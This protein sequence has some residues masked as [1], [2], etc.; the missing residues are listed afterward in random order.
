MKKIKRMIRYAFSSPILQIKS[1]QSRSDGVNTSLSEK[2]EHIEKLHCKRN[3]LRKVQVLNNYQTFYWLCL[4]VCKCVLVRMCMSVREIG[5]E[6]ITF[7]LFQ[8]S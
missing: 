5:F 7:G 6:S 1:V 2:R 3:L 8:S 4:S